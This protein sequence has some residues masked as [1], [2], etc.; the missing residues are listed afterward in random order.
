MHH[1]FRV[2]CERAFRKVP[3]MK[4]NHKP[5]KETVHLLIHKENSIEIGFF[6]LWSWFKV[7]CATFEETRILYL[8]QYRFPSSVEDI[9]FG[10]TSDL[11]WGVRNGVEKGLTVF[12]TL[13]TLLVMGNF[14]FTSELLVSEVEQTV[15]TVSEDF[16]VFWTGDTNGF[17]NVPPGDDC[18]S[19]VRLILDR[20]IKY[21]NY[22]IDEGRTEEYSFPA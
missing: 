10:G 20:N 13:T 5:Y 7:H 17:F 21:A 3:I 11:G 22:P 15:G 1:R 9:C 2:T 16:E 6:L 4:T 19:W 18:K 14:S 8:K 12:L